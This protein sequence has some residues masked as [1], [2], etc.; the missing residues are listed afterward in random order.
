[1]ATHLRINYDI[2]DKR[3]RQILLTPLQS[4]DDPDNP[5][6]VSDKWAMVVFDLF[7]L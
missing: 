3:K 2:T 6:K 5:V 1:M 7:N 4:D